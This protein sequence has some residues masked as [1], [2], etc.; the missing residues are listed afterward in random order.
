MTE[1]RG[2][3]V[4]G[5]TQVSRAAMYGHKMQGSGVTQSLLSRP[6]KLLMAP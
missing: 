3:A 4:F 5:S 1:K 2:R 6:P